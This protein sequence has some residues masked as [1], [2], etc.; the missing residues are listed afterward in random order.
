MNFTIYRRDMQLE[1]N[2]RLMSVNTSSYCGDAWWK[3]YYFYL[4]QSG[5]SGFEQEEE[6]EKYYYYYEDEAKFVI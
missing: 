6:E 1:K 4:F 5:D 3:N 2:D